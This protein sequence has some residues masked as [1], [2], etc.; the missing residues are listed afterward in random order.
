MVSQ[1]IE[2]HRSRAIDQQLDLAADK[3]AVPDRAVQAFKLFQRV[4]FDNAPEFEFIPVI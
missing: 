1:K 3:L 2:F 4:G